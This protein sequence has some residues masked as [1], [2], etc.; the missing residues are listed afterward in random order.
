MNVKELI[1]RLKQED[2]KAEVHFAYNY[3]DHW[4]TEVAP[5][6]ESVDQSEVVFSDYHSMDKLVDPE[7]DDDDDR[8]RRRVVVLGQCS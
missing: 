7:E 3:G 8:T 6:V 2:P 1:S 5:V 4:D